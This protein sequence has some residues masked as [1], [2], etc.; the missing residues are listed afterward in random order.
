[1]SMNKGIDRILIIRLSAIGDVVRALPAV[2]ALRDR[3]PTAHIA[4]V[5]EEKARDV[6]TYQPEI[7]ETIV[8]QRNRWKK[9]I[10]NPLTF[11]R[12]IGEVY[13]FV[14]ELRS[15]N[16]DIALDFHGIF[17]SGLISYISGAKERVGFGRGYCREWNHL[18]HNRKVRPKSNRISRFERN[19]VLLSSL[20]LDGGR[21]D[22]DLQVSQ[23]DVDYVNHFFQNQCPVMSGPLIAI[24]PGTSSKTSYKRWAPTNYSELADR[25]MDELKTSVLFTWGPGEK[26]MVDEI[27]TRMRGDSMVAPKTHSLKQLAEIF[28]RCSLYIGSDTGPMHI[29]SLVRTPV[30]GIYGPTDPIVNAPYE[31]TPHIIIRK[32]LPCSPCRNKGCKNVECMKA[33]SSQDVFD[34]AK[35]LLEMKGTPVG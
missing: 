13:R 33:I 29:A 34:A 6:L 15:K 7:D 12:T 2:N 14:K 21:R 20:G 1:M 24:H 23:E 28:R 31:G 17:K 27:R 19:F 30:V 10:L 16:W 18:F 3:F 32:D 11:L 35:T 5:S 22:V 25:L 4:W 26:P 8:F 9:G